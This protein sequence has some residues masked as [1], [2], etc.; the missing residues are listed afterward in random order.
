MEFDDASFDVLLLLFLLLPSSRDDDDEDAE[1][2]IRV[3][4]R[5]PNDQRVE[6]NGETEVHADREEQVLYE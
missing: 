4:P 3:C 6:T 1:E 5:V 2:Q